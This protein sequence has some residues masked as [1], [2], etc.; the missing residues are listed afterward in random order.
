MGSTFS[1]GVVLAFAVLKLIRWVDLG[2]V[3]QLGFVQNRYR[4]YF[5][6]WERST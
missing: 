5:Q 2:E 4:R 1:K 6:T 3:A